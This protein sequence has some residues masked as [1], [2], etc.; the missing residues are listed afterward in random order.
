MRRWPLCLTK[1]RKNDHWKLKVISLG[2]NCMAVIFSLALTLSHSLF[3]YI[4]WLDFVNVKFGPAPPSQYTFRTHRERRIINIR[5]NAT[6]FGLWLLL[7]SKS[8]GPSISRA[9]MQFTIAMKVCTNA[10]TILDSMQ[11]TI[12]T[13]YFFHSHS[14]SAY[15]HVCVFVC[16]ILYL[17]ISLH[18]VDVHN[19]AEYVSKDA[20]GVNKMFILLDELVD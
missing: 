17:T 12:C 18:T 19:N 7:S 9:R 1:E 8:Y 10:S 16:V 13:R 2:S 6:K 15:M 20:R 4:L 11:C 14:L 5:R 3:P